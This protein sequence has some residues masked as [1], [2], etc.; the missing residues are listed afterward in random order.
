MVGATTL[1]SRPDTVE[2]LRALMASAPVDGVAGAL[3]AMAD[4]PDATPLLGGIECPTLVV[5]G[6]EDT[7][8]VPEEMRRLAGGIPH[9]RLETIERAGHVC[10]FERPAAFN[11]AA[12]EFL[13]SLVYH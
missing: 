2:S 3:R 9:A 4:R 11:H 13:A 8:T 1:Q 5:S 10:A 12:G 6:D 7:F